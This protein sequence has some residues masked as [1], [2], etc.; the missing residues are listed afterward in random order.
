MS[1]VSRLVCRGR[2]DF[3]KNWDGCFMDLKAG[4]TKSSSVVAKSMLSM[5]LSGA[6]IYDLRTA[7]PAQLKYR[8]H[9]CSAY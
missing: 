4:L 1:L 5:T 9:S 7:T 3:S 2:S 8:M 6:Y